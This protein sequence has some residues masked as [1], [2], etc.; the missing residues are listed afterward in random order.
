ML[1]GAR[2]NISN[3]DA[4]I[5]ERALK[6]ALVNSTDYEEI[7]QFES[8]IQK[9]TAGKPSILKDGFRYDY[10]DSSDV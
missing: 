2:M 3:D 9:F 7:A 6:V 4:S 1:G 8:V 5:I 10:D